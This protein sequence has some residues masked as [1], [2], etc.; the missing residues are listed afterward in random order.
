MSNACNL[1]KYLIR[2]SWAHEFASVLLQGLF[3]LA[4]TKEMA[5]ELNQS[6][7]TCR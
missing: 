2:P 7:A 5:N 1:G 6:F 4:L 3:L